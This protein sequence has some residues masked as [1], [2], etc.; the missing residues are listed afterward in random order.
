MKTITFAIDDEISKKARIVAAH[1]DTTVNAMVRDDLTE[2]A[3][4]DESQAEAGSNSC[5]ARKRRR[6]A[7]RRTGSPTARKP[8]SGEA[9]LGSNTEVLYQRGFESRVNVRARELKIPFR[10]N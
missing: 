9:F 1:K 3:G 4:R 8:M 10:S 6:A 2:V 5:A 7:W